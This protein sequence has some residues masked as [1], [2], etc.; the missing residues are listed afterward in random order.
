[1]IKK[2]TLPICLGLLGLL[3]ISACTNAAV[4]E[5]TVTFDSTV[6]NTKISLLDNDANPCAE[7]NI[8][9]VY[10]VDVGKKALLA[11]IQNIFITAAFGSA[12]A[13]L[14]PTDAVDAY[15]LAYASEY[16]CLREEYR[17]LI[18][19]GGYSDYFFAHY[20]NLET[21]ITFNKGGLLAFSVAMDVYTGGAHG[22][23]GFLN[24]VID[25]KTG[26]L[27]TPEDVFGDNIN[28]LTAL[29]LHKLMEDNEVTTIEELNE[30]GFFD[31]VTITPNDNFSITE[32][33]ITFL[34][35]QYEIAPYVMGITEV[36]LPYREIKNLISKDTPVA[37]I[38]DL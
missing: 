17:D 18:E 15:K 34:Y 2:I 9:F 16:Q 23:A 28:E 4:T 24:Y 29:I 37:A 33:G 10:P 19:E 8:N 6:L 14:A 31:A 27:L 3:C 22:S 11:A 21:S 26:K 5:N 7:L 30:I 38:A 13:H 36:F 12:Y 25:L 1:M 32:K 20:E 35:N